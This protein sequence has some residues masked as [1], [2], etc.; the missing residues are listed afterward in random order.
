MV[1]KGIYGSPTKLHSVSTNSIFLLR[2]LLSRKD[3]HIGI[4]PEDSYM[5]EKIISIYYKYICMFSTDRL[6]EILLINM[7]KQ[8]LQSQLVSNI[9]EY[10]A[11]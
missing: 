9:S 2:L 10:K 1:I 7:T 6:S 4:F 5:R 3:F 11:I 8:S